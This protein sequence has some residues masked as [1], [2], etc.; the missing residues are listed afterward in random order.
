MIFDENWTKENDTD[1]KNFH[2]CEWDEACIMCK[3]FKE[4]EDEKKVE[5]NE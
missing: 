2:E 4:C 1:L 5:S 3:N